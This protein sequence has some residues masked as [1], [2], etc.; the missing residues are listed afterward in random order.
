MNNLMSD[1]SKLKEIEIE[2]ILPIAS[3]WFNNF[4]YPKHVRQDGRHMYTRLDDMTTRL[5][6]LVFFNEYIYFGIWL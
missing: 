4:Y 5:L 1:K 3:L 6:A 2:W